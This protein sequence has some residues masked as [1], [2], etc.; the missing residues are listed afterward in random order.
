MTTIAEDGRTVTVSLRWRDLDHQGHVYHATV[1]TL[2]DEART[3][4]LQN[5]VGVTSPDSYVVAR[6]EIDYVGEIRIDQR[7]IDVRFDV[8]RIGRTSITVGEVVTGPAGEV[9]VRAV[10][11]AVLWDRELRQPRPLEPAER[12]RLEA[13]VAATEVADA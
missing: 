2:L 7:R 6:V 8:I 9:T 13:L 11:T 12:E 4:W 5:T 3:S 1:L 10:V